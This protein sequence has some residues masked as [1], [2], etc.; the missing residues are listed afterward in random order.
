MGKA[1]Y[2]GNDEISPNL[3]ESA[4]VKSE[5]SDEKNEVV[6]GEKVVEGEE[7]VVEVAG[8]GKTE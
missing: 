5:L 2:V 6:E 3:V 8:E 7:K 4:G 1:V